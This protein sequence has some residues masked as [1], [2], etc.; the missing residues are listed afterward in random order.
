MGGV[1]TP[2]RVRRRARDRA[3]YAASPSP[4]KAYIAARYAA[5][6]E[7]VKAAVREWCAVH[8]DQVR[9]NKQ[10]WSRSEKGRTNARLQRTRYRARKRTVESTLTAIE[11][12]M[13]LA[14]GRTCGCV[15]CPAVG[16]TLDHLVPLGRGPH[17]LANIVPA[18]G[19][20]NC[21]KGARTPEEWGRPLRYTPT[22]MEVA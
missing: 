3:R 22:W 7:L 19:S 8:Q 6:P 4:V 5:N 20:C 12:R 1:V 14:E 16:D 2:Q 17:A 10:A 9:S 11:I 21:A 18:C 15:Y 13:A